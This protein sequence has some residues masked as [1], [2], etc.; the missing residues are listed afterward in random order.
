M[1]DMILLKNRCLGTRTW[2]DLRRC[3][4]IFIYICES[5][6]LLDRTIGDL[7][8]SMKPQY[9]EKGVLPRGNT[10]LKTIVRNLYGTAKSKTILGLEYRSYAEV[11]N[12]VFA[13]FEARGWLPEHASLN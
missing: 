3:F 4:V 6:N 1:F 8:Y 5:H 11:I 2:Q 9:Y 12:D 13:D 7:I 10:S